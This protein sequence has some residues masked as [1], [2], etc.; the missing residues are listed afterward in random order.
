MIFNFEIL[1]TQYIDLGSSFKTLGDYH[2]SGTAFTKDELATIVTEKSHL[3]Y[4]RAGLK[5]VGYLCD[6][7]KC[8]SFLKV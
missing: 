7:G 3:C 5:I 2:T 4:S 6:G 8:T 1:G